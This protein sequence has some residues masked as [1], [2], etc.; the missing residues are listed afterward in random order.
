MN[1]EKVSQY[2]KNI[3]GE[4]WLVEDDRDNLKV[5]YRIKEIIFTAQSPFQHIMVLDTYDFGRMLVLDGVVQSTEKDGYIYNEMIAHVPLHI[6]PH[7]KKVLIIGGGDCGAAREVIK[8]KHV[9]E[10]YFC[11]IDELVVRASKEHLT[12]V[13]AGLDDQRVHYLFADGIQYMKEHKN[14]FDIIIV[15]SSDPVGPAT[16]LFEFDFYKNVFEALKDDGLMVCQS[17]SPFFYRETMDHTFHSLS[18][19]FGHVKQYTAVVPSYPGGLW[20]FTLASK[21]YQA[22]IQPDYEKTT[23]YF[24]EEILHASF[25]LPKFMANDKK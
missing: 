8:Y 11:E 6:H 23:K 1:E 13:S 21:K 16:E 2:I 9:E 18:R 15:D 4:L 5:S 12:G 17:E 10:L 22:F 19:L 7:P 20:S 14:E 3:D 24:N 25:A